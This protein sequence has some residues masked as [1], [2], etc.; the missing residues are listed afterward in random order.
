MCEVNNMTDPEF[1]KIVL[2]EFKLIKER[3]G[4]LDVIKER[5][6]ELDVIKERLGE[7]DVIKERLGELDFIKANMVTKDDLN[8]V[9]TE[10]QKDLVAI[11]QLMDKKLTTIQETQV[12]QGESINI[13]AMWKLQSE[14]EIAALKKAK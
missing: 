5:L 10:Q 14:S 13:L 1:Q 7:L 11:L 4:E 9:I 12:V 2:D 3:L 8:K 6:G